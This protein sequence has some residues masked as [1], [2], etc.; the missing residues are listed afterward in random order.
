MAMVW[1]PMLDMAMVATTVLE[2]MAMVPDTTVLVMLMALTETEL[3]LLPVLTLLMSPFPVPVNAV[4]LMPKLKLIPHIFMLVP[5]VIL[6]MA[7]VAVLLTDTDMVWE[8]T[9]VDTTTDTESIL[10][11]MESATTTWESV[12]PANMFDQLRSQQKIS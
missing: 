5:T 4:M 3:N 11:I 10:P 1:E 7:M 12:F 2:P 9:M 6:V 8:V